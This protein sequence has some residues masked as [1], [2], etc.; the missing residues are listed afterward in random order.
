[1]T[2][3]TLHLEFFFRAGQFRRA[4][5]QLLPDREPP[6]WPK[7]LLAFHAVELAL[8]AYLIQCGVSE[9]D[10]KDEFRH[11]LK[12]LLNEAVNRGLCLPAGSKEMIADLGGRPPT[13]NQ[14]AVPPHVRIRYPLDSAVYS[15]GQFDPYI[16]HAF[17]AVARALGMQ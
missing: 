12:K 6:D 8:K 15:L 10:L 11:D 17:K 13:A 4:Y 16:E 3:P 14:A 9:E 1:M 2:S 5:E 7:Y